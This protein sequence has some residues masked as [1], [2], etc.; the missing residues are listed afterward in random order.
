MWMLARH[1]FRVPQHHIFLSRVEFSFHHG[2]RHLRLTP[3]HR[4][5]PAFPGTS[6]GALLKGSVCFSQSRVGPETLH[7][8]QVPNGRWS[9]DH[10]W[11]GPPEGPPANFR[12]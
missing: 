7:F 4:M 11:R 8:W 6:L 10:T 9:K 12:S 3:A 2:R 5:V 1:Y